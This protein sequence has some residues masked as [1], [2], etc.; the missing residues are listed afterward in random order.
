MSRTRAA[1]SPELFHRLQDIPQLVLM[2][3][4]AAWATVAVACGDM[5]QQNAGNAPV[6]TAVSTRDVHNFVAAFQQMN[7]ADSGC[8]WLEPYFRGG[9]PGLAAYDQHFG[10][11]REQL[12]ATVLRAPD[13]YARLDSASAAFDSAAAQ[14]QQLFEAFQHI[15]PAA[16]PVPMYFVVGTGIAAGT[17]VGLREPVV[18]VA[19]ERQGSTHGMVMTLLHEFVHTQQ[20]YPVIG[21]L[22]GGPQILRGSVLRHSI[23]EG[24]ADFLV[25]LVTGEPRHNVYAEAHEAELWTNFQ[26]DMHGTDYSQWLYNGQHPARGNVPPDLGYWMG[27]RITKAYY[28]NAHDKPKAVHDIL[29]IRDFDD[30]LRRSGYGGGAAAAR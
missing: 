15:D 26:R 11:D 24:S 20:H 13:R 10:V 2:V 16:R 23:A 28:E 22:T 14:T 30:F 9:T 5:A 6:T 25:E 7:P 27:Y 3:G 18:L 19:A 4:A 29:N 1:P 17:T 12:C 8:A 21:M